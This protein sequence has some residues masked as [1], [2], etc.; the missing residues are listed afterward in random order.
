MDMLQSMVQ[1]FV[2]FVRIDA[3][4][5]HEGA[6]ADLAEARLAQLGLSVARDDAGSHFGGETG[7]LI[8]RL[9]GPRV[10]QAREPVLLC[11]HLDRVVP[12]RGV[13]PLVLEDRITSSGDTVL[14]A[15]DVAGIVAILAGLRLALDT[16]EQLPPVEVAF[17]VS[18]EFGLRGS[19]H[20]DY[21]LLKSRVGYVL[22]AAGPVGT[23]I[24]A[25]PTHVVLN[26]AISGR[27]AHAAINPEDGVS[28]IQ[29]AGE[30]IAS[31]PFGRLDHRTTANIG[32]VHGGSATNIVCDRVD[33]SCEVRSLHHDRSLA[34]AEEYANTFRDAAERRGGSAHVDTL[35]HYHCYRVAP[36]S[37]VVARA[38]R[39]FAALGRT[40]TLGTTMGGSDANNF[41]QHG[42][43]SVCLGMG[44]EQVH[45]C[46][47]TI[48]LDQLLCAA[49]MVRELIL[50][51]E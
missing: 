24:I 1:E 29:I 5:G 22:D 35:V 21:S 15:D 48:P 14:A 36:T 39:V 11:A 17:T 32:S 34:L 26:V 2:E 50:A 19:K 20:M 8:G 40:C 49:Q 9:V 46:R 42:I 10:D 47:E 25:S 28:A 41:N 3:E 13:K 12:G 44:F 4:T 38:E 23:V 33:L 51:G 45:S 37:P 27:A 43:E 31:I 16:Q 30:A 7:N 18:E 6:I